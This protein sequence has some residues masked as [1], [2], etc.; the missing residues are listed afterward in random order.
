MKL[1]GRGLRTG[2]T[3]VVLEKSLVGY[4]R[5]TLVQITMKTMTNH[6]SVT[7]T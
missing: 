4:A 7:K 1:F 5:F 6:C 2:A 3:Q